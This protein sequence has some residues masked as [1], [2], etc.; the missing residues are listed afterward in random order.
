LEQSI[1]DENPALLEQALRRYHD[2][3]VAA[4]GSLYFPVP[5]MDQAEQQ[6]FAEALLVASGDM[7]CYCAPVDGI[8]RPAPGIPTLLK[9][10]ANHSAL[11]QNSA[12][13]MIHTSDDHA[14]AILRESADRSER[15]LMVFNFRSEAI[16][17]RVDTQA[18]HATR[19][20]DVVRRTS[21]QPDPNGLTVKL[22]A[23]SYQI[24]QVS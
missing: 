13:R 22:A 12:R 23:H 20:V 5:R 6:G 15:L 21:S 4:G 9:F 24:F 3:V 14:Y 17:L 7:L 19:Y 10:K 8:T 1:R 18:I 2:R 16:D 11:F